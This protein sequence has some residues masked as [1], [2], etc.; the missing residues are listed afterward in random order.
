MGEIVKFPT[1]RH[2][3]RLKP[4]ASLSQPLSHREEITSTQWVISEED[5]KAFLHLL[6]EWP[7]FESFDAPQ[8]LAELFQ[9]YYDDKLTLSQD[10][11]IEFMLHMHDADSAFDI[12]HALFTWEE[13]DKE[14]F[15]IHLSMHAELIASVK[16][17]EI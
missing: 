16:K 11:V 1:K 2:S 15:L 14:F 9:Q 5:D 6:T 4:P 12:G 17:E 13:D 7:C 8:S 3:N 10:C